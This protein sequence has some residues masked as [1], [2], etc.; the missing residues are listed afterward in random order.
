MAGSNL[1][2]AEIGVKLDPRLMAEVD[3]W[4]RIYGIS[5]LK[6][7][8][9]Y[10]RGKCIKDKWEIVNVFGNSMNVKCCWNSNWKTIDE[11]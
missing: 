2:T 9:Y 10:N 3:L 6:V 5:K 8:T 1:K 11:Y 4:P 7:I